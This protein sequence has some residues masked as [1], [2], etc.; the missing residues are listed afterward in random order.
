MRAFWKSAEE[1]AAQLQKIKA[2]LEEFDTA[3]NGPSPPL[4]RNR[5]VM[6]TP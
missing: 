2:E 6:I 3:R 5:R 1:T 4:E